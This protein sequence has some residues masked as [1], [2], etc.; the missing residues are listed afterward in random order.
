[1]VKG[2]TGDEEAYQARAAEERAKGGGGREGL[3]ARNMKSAQELPLLVRCDGSSLDS[4]L[5]LNQR[6]TMRI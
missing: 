5:G 4:C 6:Q 3:G 1:M 2:E